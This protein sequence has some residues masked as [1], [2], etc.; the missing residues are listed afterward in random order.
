MSE[1]KESSTHSESL[2]RTNQPPGLKKA[3][4]KITKKEDKCGSKVYKITKPW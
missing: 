1:E 4:K 2:R 3:S